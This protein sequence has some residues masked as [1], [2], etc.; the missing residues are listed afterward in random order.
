MSAATL[1][2]LAGA[3]SAAI[4]AWRAGQPISVARYLLDVAAL[5]AHL[6]ASGPMINLCT[7]RYTFAVALGAALQRGQASLLPPNARPDTVAQLHQHAALAYG[8]TDDA[9]LQTPGVPLHHLPLHPLALDPLAFTGL[10]AQPSPVGAAPICR[11][12]LVFTDFHEFCSTPHKEN[13]DPR[14]MRL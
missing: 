5:A 3:D 7:D 6:P 13:S 9:A 1:P 10:H 2:L 14:P 4:L 11:C 12:K 8:L